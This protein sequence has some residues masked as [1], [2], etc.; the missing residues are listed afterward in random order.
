[1]K[2]SQQIQELNFVVERGLYN[3]HI[4]SYEF[5]SGNQVDYSFLHH[6]SIKKWETQFYFKMNI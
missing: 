6:R 5:Q 3:I 2:N 1:M 4:P